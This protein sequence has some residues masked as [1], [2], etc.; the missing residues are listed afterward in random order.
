MAY[1][2]GD[3]R[4]MTFLP[5][6]IDEY[7]GHEDPVRVYDAFGD[8]LDLQALGI[9]GQP[10][11]AGANAYHPRAMVKTAEGVLILAFVLPLETEEELSA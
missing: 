9:P 2:I 11:K 10:Y 5:P 6:I 1:K 3:R 7:I 4:Q 8:V